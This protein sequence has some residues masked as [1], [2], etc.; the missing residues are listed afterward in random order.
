MR[1]FTVEGVHK[2]PGGSD[3]RS[4]I[5]QHQ[6]ASLKILSRITNLIVEE[7]NEYENMTLVLFKEKRKGQ[8]F[9]KTNFL[10]GDNHDREAKRAKVSYP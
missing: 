8:T 6:K 2:L 7:E 9:Y 4:L 5:S 3:E 1:R 10:T